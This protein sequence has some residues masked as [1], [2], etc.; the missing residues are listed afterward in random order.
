M[1]RVQSCAAAPARSSMPAWSELS[2]SLW[3]RRTGRPSRRLWRGAPTRSAS[4]LSR[5]AGSAPG[6]CCTLE[7]PPMIDHEQLAE[8]LHRLDAREREVLHLSLRRRGPDV[9][10]GEVLGGDAQDVARRRAAAIDRLA[11]DMTGQR[12]GGPGTKPNALRG[13]GSWDAG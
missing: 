10:L 3:S 9:A 13:A 8:A 7:F 12:G 2:S 5:A 6:T 11:E 4:K 1:R